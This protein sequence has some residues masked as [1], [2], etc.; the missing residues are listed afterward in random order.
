MAQWRKGRQGNG[1]VIHR[2]I[3]LTTTGSAGSAAAAQWVHTGP[4]KLTHVKVNFHA[5]TAATADFLIRVDPTDFEAGTGGYTALTCTD[6]T[7]DIDIRA[8]GQPSATDEARNATAATDAVDGGAFVKGGVHVSTAQND[9]LTDAV[10][11]DLWFE[12]LRYEEVTLIS[13]SGADG[14]GIVTRSLPLQGAGRLVGLAIDFQNMPA[15]TDLLIKADS[16]DGETL[17]TSTSSNTDIGTA[18]GRAL[19]IVGID[20]GN[21][22]LAATDGSTGGAPFRSGLFFDVAE[23]DAFTS[24]NEKIVIGCWVT[25]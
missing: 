8:L 16:T 10:V 13:Q 20:E 14:A 1:N 24:G 5:S 2:Q 15:T 23:A 4:A 7:T 6:T 19:G 11:V 17:F 12:R 3:K 21:A 18:Q 9:A 22:A 25:Q